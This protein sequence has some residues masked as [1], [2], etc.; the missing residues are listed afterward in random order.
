[1]RPGRRHVQRPD[2]GIRRRRHHLRQPPPPLHP[3]PHE[4]HPSPRGEPRAPGDD[5]H[6][7][8][9]RSAGNVLPRSVPSSLCPAPG[10]T[11]AAARSGGRAPGALLGAV[12]R[13]LPG[14]ATAAPLLA[15]RNVSKT[16]SVAPGPLGARRLTLRAVDD[17]SF[18][19]ATGETL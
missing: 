16:S 14:A 17:A 11:A 19:S 18:T 9:R 1:R 3:R 13:P 4:L 8:G 12:P 6:T 2:H 10:E 5:P 15:L 7:A